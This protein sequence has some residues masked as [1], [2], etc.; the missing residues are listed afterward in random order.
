MNRILNFSSNTYGPLSQ[1]AKHNFA[2]NHALNIYNSK[3]IYTFIPKNACS[4]MRTSLAIANGCIERSDDFNWIHSNN[5][6]FKASLSE[7]VTA[8]YTFVILRSPYTRLASVYLDKV[9]DKTV[10]LWQLN[11]A[12]RRKIDVTNLTFEAFVKLMSQPGI[13]RANIHWRPQVDFLVYK[14]YDDY[15]SL[16]KN[17]ETFQIIEEKTGINIVDARVLTKHGTDRYKKVENKPFSLIPANEI[18]T[19]KMEGYIP[20]YST[21]FNEELISL[22][23]KYYAEDIALYKSKFDNTFFM[24]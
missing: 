14:Q 2:T 23:S 22:V 24:K 4:T 18:Y 21:L 19:M 9:V 15:F 6:T 1:N 20:T 16:E 10:E 5:Q 3:A 8:D 7:L 17:K 12:L 13:F 11:D